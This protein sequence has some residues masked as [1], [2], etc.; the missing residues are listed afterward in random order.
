MKD[1]VKM[2]KERLAILIGQNGTV[3]KDL[4]KRTCT[5]ITVTDDVEI[6]GEAVD[7][8]LASNI[9]KAI[10]RGFSPENAFL[11]MNEE[12]ELNII[13][14]EGHSYKL[15][16][17]LMGRVIGTQGNT[18]KKIED[19]C[20]ARISIYGKTVAIISKLDKSEAAMKC[21]EALLVGKTHGYAYRVMNDLKKR[22]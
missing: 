17:R 8:M 9:V 4:E 1:F 5:K 20:G 22:D 12:Y 2:P 18:R 7:V 19:S 10:A 15:V 13:T 16:K 11:L 6:E 21:I 3:K 14:L